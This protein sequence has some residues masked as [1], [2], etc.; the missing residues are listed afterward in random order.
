[1]HE[2]EWPGGA[3]Q[4]SSERGQAGPGGNL[5][6][7]TLSSLTLSHDRPIFL[8]DRLPFGDLCPPGHFCPAGTENPRQR[9]CPVGTWNAE[10]GAPDVSWCLP[11]PP[12]LFCAEVGQ[13]AP[14][15]PCASGER[16]FD[17]WWEGTKQRG[18][19]QPPRSWQTES[20][21]IC[22][23][24]WVCAN[25]NKGPLR[26]QM[27]EA[28]LQPPK[29]TSLSTFSASRI[30]LSRRGTDPKTSWWAL[31]KPRHGGPRLP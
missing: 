18:A 10:R 5:A 23:C 22:L 4:A 14:R 13:A 16:A 28:G 7:T 19:S 2:Q 11:C 6:E 15:G 17:R 21:E 8:Q 25:W 9:P 27:Q 29:Q 3:G 12:G 1:M 31:G 26:I 20:R 30:L 24:G